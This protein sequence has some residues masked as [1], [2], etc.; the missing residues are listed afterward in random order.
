[1]KVHMVLEM[2][3]HHKLYAKAS[4]FLFGHSSVGFLGHVISKRG[5]AVDPTQGRRCCRAGHAA[6]VNQRVPLRQSS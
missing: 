5:V 4:K 1:M 3:G 2:L 6:V